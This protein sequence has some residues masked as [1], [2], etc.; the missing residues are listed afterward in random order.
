[1]RDG[2]ID[3]FL[4][5]LRTSLNR[6]SLQLISL[7]RISFGDSLTAVRRRDD[8]FLSGQAVHENPRAFLSNGRCGLSGILIAGQGIFYGECSSEHEILD[9]FATFGFGRIEARVAFSFAVAGEAADEDG[10]FV[11]A[12]VELLEHDDGAACVSFALQDGACDFVGFGD[13]RVLCAVPCEDRVVH[14]GG[15]TISA[16]D[17]LQVVGYESELGVEADVF[18]GVVF[19]GE[20]HVPVGGGAVIAGQFDLD[21]FRVIEGEIKLPGLDREFGRRRSVR[22]RRCGVAGYVKH[23]HCNS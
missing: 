13:E 15:N 19:H 10:E 8:G 20:Q 16:V 2:V 5:S 3:R 21:S 7:Q 4:V 6:T 23:S 12:F 18:P 1:M 22:G 14:G 11:R 17:G 9:V